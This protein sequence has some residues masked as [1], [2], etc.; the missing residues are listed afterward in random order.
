MRRICHHA[1]VFLGIACLLTTCG[2]S[3]AS[4]SKALPPP[5]RV[6]CSKLPSNLDAEFDELSRSFEAGDG[7]P[8]SRGGAIV[9]KIVHIQDAG[10][11]ARCLSKYR[12]L[13]HCMVFRGEDYNKLNNQLCALEELNAQLRSAIF[14]SGGTLA[15]EVSS[16]LD[17]LKWL[18][19]ETERQS[20]SKKD[21][22]RNHVGLFVTGEAYLECLRQTYD[23]QLRWL[24]ESFNNHVVKKLPPREV[25]D[26][27]REVEAFIGRRI[28]TNEE[29]LRDRRNRKS[30]EPR[31]QPAEIDV[32]AGV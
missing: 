32:S 24:E 30:T 5:P 17:F 4:D 9:E 26:L 22:V 31:V 13:L 8:I 27:R 7:S 28:R 21:D 29:I 10:D 12:E 23:R 3:P 18:K 6:A 19:K 15:E 16:R 1:I 25:E 20:A 14:R 11:R 2:C